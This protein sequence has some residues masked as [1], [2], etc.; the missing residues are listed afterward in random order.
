MRHYDPEKPFFRWFRQKQDCNKLSLPAVVDMGRA[1]P[2][3]NASAKAT[4]QEATPAKP[5]PIAN[6]RAHAFL[7]QVAAVHKAYKWL[8][9]APPPKPAQ[10]SVVASSA[11]QAAPH[12]KPAKPL[13]KFD[14]QDLLLALDA[15]GFKISAALLRKW[16]ANPAYSVQSPEQKACTYGAALYPAYLVDANTVKHAELLKFERAKKAYEQIKTQEF[17]ESKS[18]RDAL[19]KILRKVP[20]DVVAIDAEKEFGADL[21]AMH[22]KYA[23]ASITFGKQFPENF[24]DIRIN[25][26]DKSRETTDDLELALGPFTFFA[27]I[28]RCTHRLQRQNHT[29]GCGGICGSVRHGA[30]WL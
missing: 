26:L 23:F 21:Q 29:Q 8:T 1:A 25:D 16:F 7:D 20:S 24:E 15:L 12:E 10:A 6:A 30:L 11:A 2:P 9:V 4:A 17:L 18:A 3:S 5:A 28:H 14:L 13:D 19:A 27:A 22:R